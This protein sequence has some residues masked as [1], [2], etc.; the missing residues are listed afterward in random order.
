[1]NAYYNWG[2]R[3]VLGDVDKVIQTTGD[4]ALR[5]AAQ[6]AYVNLSTLPGP[7]TVSEMIV[8][9]QRAFELCENPNEARKLMGFLVQNPD[10]DIAAM[11]G[12]WRGHTSHGALAKS[13]A[14][15]MTKLI[16][17]IAELKPGEE[18]KGNKARVRGDKRAAINSATSSL[19]SWVSPETWFSWNFKAPET[20]VYFVEVSQS[21][22]QEAPSQFVVYL[23][24]KTLP[25]ESKMTGALDKFETIRLKSPVHLEA[26]KVYAISLAAGQR[27]Q[28]RM[29]DIGGIRIVKAE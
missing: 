29:M 18:M 10:P 26:G 19:T 9:W 17:G 3:S 12:K 14:E 11:V 7:E 8:I 24:G 6:R 16:A 13:T 25:G 22:L 28:P 4:T 23:A 15:T 1:M 20:G 5:S 2:D 21:Y 27:V